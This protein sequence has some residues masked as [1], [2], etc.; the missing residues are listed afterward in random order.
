[1]MPALSHSKQKGKEKSWKGG[2]RKRVRA[3]P[4]THMNTKPAWAQ[5]QRRASRA[6]VDL[7]FGQYYFTCSAAVGAKHRPIM[8]TFMQ[9]DV[10]FF[11]ETLTA[12]LRHPQRPLPAWQVR[13]KL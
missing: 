13:I 8:F 6:D 12:V 1:M 9:I 10:A 7:A 4:H 11:G 5:H 2:K 3:H